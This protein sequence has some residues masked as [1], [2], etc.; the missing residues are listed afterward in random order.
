MQKEFD[1]GNL[2]VL[3]NVGSAV[4][5]A[6]RIRRARIA[7]ESSEVESDDED[8]D[9]DLSVDECLALKLQEAQDKGLSEDGT[10]RLKEMLVKFRD[11]FRVSF[12]H[13]PPVDVE[14]L[15]RSAIQA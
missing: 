1:I 4:S 11:V 14:P 5:R 13:D 15:D 9:A 10:A 2:S 3:D 7:A 12:Q 8:D 6:L